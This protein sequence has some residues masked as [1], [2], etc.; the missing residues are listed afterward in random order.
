MHSKKNIIICKFINLNNKCKFG[1]KCKFQHLNSNEI[2]DII[3][4]LEDLK[5]ENKSLKLE[6]KEIKVKKSA[7]PNTH[8]DVT[9]GKLENSKMLY[10]SFFNEKS[11]YRSTKILLNR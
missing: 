7:Q 5:L 1:K 11:K 6:L 2:N 8:C 4:K 10:S 3:A 9:N